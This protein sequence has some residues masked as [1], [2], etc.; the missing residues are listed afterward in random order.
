MSDRRRYCFLLI[1]FA[2]FFKLLKNIFVDTITVLMLENTDNNTLAVRI[3]AG[4]PDAEN[5]LFSQLHE[6]IRFLVQ[7]RSRNFIPPDD[8]EDIISEI[9][10]AILHSLRKGGFDPDRGKPLQAYIAG[11]VQNVVGQY[12][13]KLN[14]ENG[15]FDVEVSEIHDNNENALTVLI[16]EERSR[17]LRAYLNKLKPKYREILQLRIYD[18]K[19]IEEIALELNIERRR[20][21][22]R[23]HY[24]IKLLLKECRQ[25]NYFQYYDRIDK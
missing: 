14:K 24:A 5:I 12:F 16:N 19:S 11:I 15:R 21:S 3:A 8:Q 7:V 17:K 13:R 9:H 18:N 4:D 22:E 23:I 1:L 10:E 2:N 6:K 25:D 20:V